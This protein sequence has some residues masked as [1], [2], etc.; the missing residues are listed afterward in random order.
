MEIERTKQ[1]HTEIRRVFLPG[2]SKELP[3][4]KKKVS[5]SLAVLLLLLISPNVM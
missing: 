1:M 2:L 4:K 5:Y 3:L